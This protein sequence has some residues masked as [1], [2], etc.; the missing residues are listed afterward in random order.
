M[1]RS[2]K[3]ETGHAKNREKLTHGFVWDDVWMRLT[4]DL[5]V[6]NGAH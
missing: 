1:Q 2:A 6:K 4:R 5:G 3:I